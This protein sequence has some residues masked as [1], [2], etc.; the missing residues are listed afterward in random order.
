L[1]D[2]STHIDKHCTVCGAKN[3]SHLFF[4]CNLPQQV[5][6]T[7]EV[8]SFTHL[9]DPMTDGV[10]NIFPHILPPNSTD[11]TMTKTLLL[12]YIW[13]ARNDHR[14]QRKV[15]TPVQV[16]HAATAHFNTNLT[17]WG[18]QYDAPVPQLSPTLP[19]STLQ[20]YRCY[21]DAATAPDSNASPPKAA[22]L[23]IFIINTDVNPPFSIF[24]NTYMQD[25][26]SVLM[27]ESTALALAI[28]LCRRMNLQHT[29]FFSDSQ[30]LVN[31]F[32]GQHPNDPPDWMIK[33][34]T[35]AIQ[36]SL[37]DT[38]NILHIS[39]SRNQMAHTLATTALHNLH[40]HYV[41][42]PPV[43][44]NVSHTLGFPLF[45]ALQSVSLNNV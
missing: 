29:S 12:W 43:C 19:P 16:H 27:A 45:D 15:W 10:Q 13:K 37:H 24:I 1:A 8:N 23:G 30:L 22:G 40:T 36:I 38:Y 34:Y 32:N 11:Q 21:T 41:S 26:T 17:S 42:Q 9:I 3:D 39:R 14:Y 7:S 28:S 31:C 20:G 18:D 35:Q 5:W 2:F 25:S 6:D 4:M 33:P 44:T